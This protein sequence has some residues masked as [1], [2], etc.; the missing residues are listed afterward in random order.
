MSDMAASFSKHAR[1]YDRSRRQLVPCFD[2]FYGMAVALEPA[3]CDDE[4]RVLDLGAGSGLLAAA[5]AEAYP[6]ATFTLVD[7]APAMLD[8]ARE[9]FAGERR[10]SY[11]CAD[12]GSFDIENCYDAAISALAIHHLEDGAK[13]TLFLR[14]HSALEPGGAF[15]NADQVLG[16]TPALAERNRLM[17]L[18]GARRLGVSDDDLAAAIERMTHDRM[19]TIE[20]QLRW[21]EDAGFQAVDCAYEN[22]MFAVYSGRR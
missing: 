5:Y 16:R 2:E 18:E 15:I 11:V 20:H 1:I 7:A 12:I 17:W 19:A 14:I 4:L 21:M 13:R 6:R 8:L 9:R 3:R 22:G 10:F